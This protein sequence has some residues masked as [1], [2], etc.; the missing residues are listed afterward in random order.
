[1]ASPRKLRSRARERYRRHVL[2]RD[3]YRCRYC[4]ARGPLTLDHVVPLARGG[5]N[6]PCNLAAACVA[7]NAAKGDRTP[8][9][10]ARTGGAPSPF[11]AAYTRPRGPS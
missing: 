5:A 10:W 3:G 8:A 9:E 7:C 6:R 1:M 4:G 2:R 11:P